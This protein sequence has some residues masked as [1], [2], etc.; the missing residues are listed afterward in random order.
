MLNELRP[1]VRYE[2]G[3]ASC[4]P[5]P[6]GDSRGG[7]PAAGPGVTRSSWVGP[8]RDQDSTSSFHPPPGCKMKPCP[9]GTKE[10][11]GSFSS[12]RNKGCAVMETGHPLWVENE[13]SGTGVLF[14]E[15]FLAWSMHSDTYRCISTFCVLPIINQYSVY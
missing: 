3:D 7:S 4:P 10:T 11:M 14:S 5:R 1:S 13:R 6:G 8:D 15:T 9:V 2:P 12:L